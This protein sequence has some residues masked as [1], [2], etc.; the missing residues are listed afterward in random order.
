MHDAPGPSSPPANV[1]KLVP[2]SVEP[3]PQTYHELGQLLMQLGE[4]DD[5]F[6]AFQQGLTQ[7]Y[8]GQ[9]LPRLSDSSLSD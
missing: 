1:S 6:R 3:A 2:L 9:E 7:S 5:A 8:G 4:Q